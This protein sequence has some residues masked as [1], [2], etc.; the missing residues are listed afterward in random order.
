[1]LHDQITVMLGIGRQHLNP[2]FDRRFDHPIAAG[3]Q[4]EFRA[5]IDPVYRLPSTVY[6]VNFLCPAPQSV[7]LYGPSKGAPLAQASSPQPSS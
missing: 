3:N 4:A 5:G 6:R 2:I 1:M 7:S